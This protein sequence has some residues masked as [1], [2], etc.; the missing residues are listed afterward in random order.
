MT[1]ALRRVWLPWL[2]LLV[3]TLL[4]G[5]VALRLLWQEQRR[6]DTAAGEVRQRAE[7]ATRARAQVAADNI[8]LLVSEIRDGLLRE[9][10]ETP[11][12]ELEPLLANW[13]QTNPLVAETF[14]WRSDRAV[15]AWP[16][17][18]TA[19]HRSFRQRHAALFGAGERSLAAAV[20]QEKATNKLQVAKDEAPVAAPRAP[21]EL[22]SPVA[23]IQ[24]GE[25]AFS[26]N[27]E[28]SANQAARLDVQQKTRS[29]AVEAKSMANSDRKLLRSRESAKMAEETAL[30]TTAESAKQK[31]VQ[32]EPV[33]DEIGQVSA[34]PASRASAPA[35]KADV[36]AR[37]SMDFARTPPAPS[38][39]LATAAPEVLR[40]NGNGHAA[41]LVMDAAA[42][43]WSEPASGWLGRTVDGAVYF[44]GWWQPAGA[45]AVRGVELNLPAVLERVQ[46]LVPAATADGERFALRGPGE[47]LG[48]ATVRIPLATTLP[49]W[50]LVAWSGA[51]GRLSSLDSGGAFFVVAALLVGAFAISIL[52]GGAMFFRQAAAA[53]HEA[54][55]KTS[56]VSNVSHEM[57][58][59]L[60]T[61]RMYAEMLADERVD[62]PAKRQRYFATIG[63]ETTRLTRLVNNALDFGRLE[64]GRKEY[65][66]ESIPL[67]P[68]LARLAEVHAPRVAEAGLQLTVTP[69]SAD[70]AVRCDPDSLDQMVLNLVDNAV[71]Y[72]AA[73]GVVELRAEA[74]A[75]GW[76]L[77][78]ADRGPGVPASHRERIFERFHRVDD[79]L[80]AKEQGAGLGL[81]IARRLARDQRGNLTCR[82][83]VGGGTEFVLT[84]P[85]AAV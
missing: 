1:P 42:V 17:A 57:K 37:P 40:R 43:P 26:Y 47:A 44:L 75:G 7:A 12:R 78:V 30:R 16:P 66:P 33:A 39:G 6:I 27:R 13:P 51:P 19:E 59:P 67:A 71:K 68:W 74:V 56:F 18:D 32:E 49:G 85:V 80:T 55:L 79:S 31:R 76:A 29:S 84:L 63:R 20:Q 21:Q 72:A 14:L 81:T 69:P 35:F 46:A 50:T 24:T 8:E 15:L 4:I 25:D 41:P 48:G 83:R 58:T 11:E 61:I 53:A 52:A 73:G 62:D 38:A 70:A 77:I 82:E 36:E 3:P 5:A 23:Q 28:V 64:A 10:A 45:G 34:A 22:E 9:L 60:T 2:L 65:R 54:A